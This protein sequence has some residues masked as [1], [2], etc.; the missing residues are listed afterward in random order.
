MAKGLPRPGAG[1]PPCPAAGAALWRYEPANGAGMGVRSL[2]EVD[3]EPVAGDVLEPG[4]VFWVLEEAPGPEGVVFLRLAG[5]GWAF[6]WKPGVGVMCVPHE[7]LRQGVDEAL[8]RAEAASGSSGRIAIRGRYHDEHRRLEDDYKVRMSHVLGVGVNG[9]VVSGWSRHTGAKVA[10]KFLDLASAWSAERKARLSELETFLSV[11]HPHIGRLVDVYETPSGLALV[12]EYLDGGELF[13][14]LHSRGRFSEQDAARALRQVLLAVRHLHRRG[15]VHRD[16][17]LE[18]FLYDCGSGDLKLIDF[19]FAR[20]WSGEEPM[21]GQCGTLCYMAPEVLDSEDGY[22]FK[23]DL[24]SAGVIAFALLAGELPFKGVSEKQVAKLIRNASYSFAGERW[25]GISQAGRDFVQSLLQLDAAARPSAADA[26]RHPWFAEQLAPL[27]QPE[28]PRGEAMTVA[29]QRFAAA[30]P[31]RQACLRLAA[32][33]A[34][35][36]AARSASLREAQACAQQEFLRLEE[37]GDGAAFVADLGCPAIQGFAQDG[38]ISYSDCLA[39]S[40]TSKAGEVWSRGF[41][42]DTFRRLCA[43]ARG[44]SAAATHESARRVLGKGA[45]LEGPFAEDRKGKAATIEQ[46]ARDH[47]DSVKAAAH[48]PCTERRKDAPVACANCFPATCGGS[49]VCNGGSACEPSSPLPAGCLAVLYRMLCSLVAGQGV[50][51]QADGTC[52]ALVLRRCAAFEARCATAVSETSRQPR[53]VRAKRWL[54]MRFL[55]DKRWGIVFSL[56][57][58]LGSAAA[59]SPAW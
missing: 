56:P 55:S 53:Q 11:D 21:R 48:H 31:Y 8:D 26:L 12:M 10:V 27:V 9:S 54:G 4:D 13:D 33:A 35:A 32:C 16:L 20:P 45:M 34:P 17:K 59:S 51:G 36:A 47:N 29:L 58:I 39:A 24:W 19:G 52:I 14:R 37:L 49:A 38:E 3:A 44:S 6:D 7:S 43:G 46:L 22:D 50:G 18:N 41:A 40:L 15:I 30:P 42:R 5:G 23:C 1:L 25:A 28:P 57:L 2:P